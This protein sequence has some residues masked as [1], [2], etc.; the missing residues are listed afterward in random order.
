[1][2]RKD[3][4]ARRGDKVSIKLKRRKK[5][6]SADAAADDRRYGPPPLPEEEEGGVRR[7]NITFHDLSA[8]L[9]TRAVEAVA[10]GSEIFANGI[11]AYMTAFRDI[12][13]ASAAVNV[14]SGGTF[15]RERWQSWLA[16]QAF[17]TTSLGYRLAPRTWRLPYA[18]V[19]R[20][21]LEA[22]IGTRGGDVAPG[23]AWKKAP[24]P[25]QRLERATDPDTIAALGSEVAE[26]S[27][28]FAKICNADATP[29]RWYVH[30]SQ[31][32]RNQFVEYGVFAPRMGA[33][34]R[35]KV[36]GGI[37]YEPFDMADTDN[38]LVARRFVTGST[39]S[40]YDNAI[41]V[42]APK[43]TSRDK[44]KVFLVPQ[45]WRCDLEWSR[46]I[47]DFWVHDNNPQPDNLDVR[48]Y[49][50]AVGAQSRAFWFPALSNPLVFQGAQWA[51]LIIGKRHLMTG[52][53]AAWDPTDTTEA[54][55]LR[56]MSRLSFYNDLSGFPNEPGLPNV[57]GTDPPP[58]D[59]DD[60][61]QDP[62]WDGNQLV[63]R[64]RASCV[65]S[66]APAPV[67]LLVG[68]IE[69]APDD[70][71]RWLI[72][73]KTERAAGATLFSGPFDDIRYIIA[74]Q[75]HNV[76]FTVIGRTIPQLR[77]N[78][79][80]DSYVITPTS[81]QVLTDPTHP[82]L[83]FGAWTVSDPCGSQWFYIQEHAIR[84]T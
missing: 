30:A 8:R 71:H 12:Q 7:A 34:G 77:S 39:L 68:G 79:W 2:T 84:N 75:T 3:I 70:D 43:I 5:R 72:F 81:P 57:P 62:D 37:Y 36:E 1:M 32:I 35:L 82:P 63:A 23:A 44:V 16:A 80:S 46:V 58:P 49:T 38:F 50:E 21:A 33:A 15:L 22:R 55:R 78:E 29:Y 9:K 48:Y 24:T 26:S 61:P 66:V 83:P 67:G 52:S 76:E 6:V 73:R 31:D 47:V 56:L 45:V 41:E 10:S 42:E 40:N 20:L 59:A 28:P 11:M 53:D 69:T 25:A 4:K 64:H 19:E 60:P 65:V 74:T 13:L 14:T 27:L 51:D 54:N 17:Q 18:N